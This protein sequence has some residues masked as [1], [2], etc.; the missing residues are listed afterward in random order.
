MYGN[1]LAQLAQRTGAKPSPQI[2]QPPAPGARL[3]TAPQVPMQPQEP[4]E[5]DVATD[6][7]WK[8]FPAVTKGDTGVFLNSLKPEQRNMILRI[9]LKQTM[10]GKRPSGPSGGGGARPPGPPSPLAAPAQQ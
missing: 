3:G 2:G 1:V 8:I 6:P 5:Y 9:L 10:A 4:D 7:A